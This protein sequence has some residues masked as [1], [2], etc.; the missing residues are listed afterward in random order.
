M[1]CCNPSRACSRRYS[2]SPW[3]RRGREIRQARLVQCQRQIA[4][5]RDLH[6]VLQRLREIGEQLRHLG[7]G[8][9]ILLCGEGPCAALVVEHIAFGDAHPRLVRL[10]IVRAEELHR[11]GGNHRQAQFRGQPGRPIQVMLFVGESGALQLDVVTVVEQCRPFPRE[12]L[13]LCGIVG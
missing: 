6:A 3:S 13:R 10:E 5:A 9:E 11:M 8:L 12:L 7:L 2:S 4:A 1:R